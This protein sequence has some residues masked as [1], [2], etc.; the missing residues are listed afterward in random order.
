MGL[1]DFERT[2]A[3]TFSYY[4]SHYYSL[5]RIYDPLSVKVDVLHRAI[6]SALRWTP[7][8]PPRRRR[9]GS[10]TLVWRAVSLSFSTSARVEQKVGGAILGLPA[11]VGANAA[12]PH[13]PP[14]A[15]KGSAVP[16]SFF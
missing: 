3:K 1:V 13:N 6:L 8:D 10:A 14:I 16:Q 5:I 12:L 7:H 2:D 15:G 9:Q 4:Y 11:P